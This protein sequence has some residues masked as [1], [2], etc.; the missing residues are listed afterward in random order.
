MSSTEPEL[1]EPSDR[2]PATYGE[3]SG[4]P[5][6][7]GQDQVEI[8]EIVVQHVVQHLESLEIHSGP[9]PPPDD[10]ERYELGAL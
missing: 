8:R 7:P 1:P 3:D 10:L 4:F 2:D 6:G 5:V 9:L